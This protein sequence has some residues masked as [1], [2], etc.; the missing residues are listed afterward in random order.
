MNIHNFRKGLVGLQSENK[1]MKMIAASMIMGNLILGYALVSKTQ[2]ITIVPP[3][4]TE[5]A[6]LDE[7]AA[8]SSYMKAW[9]LY[10]A[11]SLGNANPAS[12]DLLKKSIGPFLDASIYTKVM[13]AMDDQ[14]DQI[15]RDRITL[16]FNPIGVVTDPLAV[17]T[18]YVSG[19]QTLEGITG[20]PVTTPVYYEISAN[21]KGY[22]PI[23]TFIEIK[24]GQ[25]QLPT[26][27]EKRKGQSQKK[28][29]AG[30]TS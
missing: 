8:S 20:K 1:M 26:E 29:S 30:K 24:R 10:I 25:P 9:A 19:N 21:V 27:L 12:L 14:I 11:D 13:N 3:N 28:S 16:S 4:L 15:K 7:K 6:W 18:F 22:R 2:P 5:T 23:I 17:G